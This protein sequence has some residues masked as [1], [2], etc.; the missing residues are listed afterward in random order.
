VPSGDQI[1]RERR[2]IDGA[3][4]VVREELARAGKHITHEQAKRRVAE[5]CERKRRDR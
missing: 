4:A 5:A 2:G 3:A 1:D